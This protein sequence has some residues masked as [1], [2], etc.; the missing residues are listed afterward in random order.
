MVVGKFPNRGGQWS[1]CLHQI[2]CFFLQYLQLYYF[3]SWVPV[4]RYVNY[5]YKKRLV[6]LTALGLIKETTIENSKNIN[7]RLKFFFDSVD[8]HK[9][10]LTASSPVFASPVSIL[11]LDFY[12]QLL[13]KFLS[14]VYTCLINLSLL[15]KV[16][17]PI[18]DRGRR[19]F[20]WILIL[21]TKSK[22]HVI[23]YCITKMLKP[24]NAFIYAKGIRH[25]IY[26]DGERMAA[27]SKKNIL[28][29]VNIGYGAV[30]KL[31]PCLIRR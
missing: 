20:E 12:V 15:R 3:R 9:F 16:N 28:D 23:V 13:T 21:E 30:A 14:F 31:S 27:A 10:V 1:G 6:F 19:T 2:N 7:Q 8:V 18:F 25:S 11:P 5:E 4:I 29:I 22:K 24:V 26:L 17:S